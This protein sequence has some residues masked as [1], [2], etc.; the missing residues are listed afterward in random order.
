MLLSHRHHGFAPSL[1]YFQAGTPPVCGVDTPMNTL[2]GLLSLE[3]A[4]PCID[5][6]SGRLYF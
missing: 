1:I 5:G 2:L 6:S 4:G 3:A